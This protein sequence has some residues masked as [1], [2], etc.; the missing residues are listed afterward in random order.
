MPI[1]PGSRVLVRRGHEHA[2]ASVRAGDV[3]MVTAVRERDADVEFPA[4]QIAAGTHGPLVVAIELV[5]LEL[6]E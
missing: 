5:G 6:L 2:E 3:G 1:V 4:K